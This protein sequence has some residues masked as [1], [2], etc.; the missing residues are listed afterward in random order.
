MKAMLRSLQLLCRG[1]NLDFKEASGPLFCLFKQNS[2]TAASSTM[3]AH[4]KI[5]RCFWG[6]LLPEQLQSELLPAA[7]QGCGLWH[8]L[9]EGVQWS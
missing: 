3:K 5:I 4:F 2:L 9:S 8:Q 6:L 7:F 1:G